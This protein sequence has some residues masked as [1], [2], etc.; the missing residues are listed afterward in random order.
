LY[1]S[2]FPTDPVVDARL[3]ETGIIGGD[4]TVRHMVTRVVESLADADQHFAGPTGSAAFAE[5]LG[6]Q[7]DAGRVV[8]SAPIMANAGRVTDRPLVTCAAPS[9]SLAGELVD[10][11]ASL[12]R[13]VRLGLGTGLRFDGVADPLALLHY[14]N[15]VAV[16]E[17][18]TGAAASAAGTLPV[19]H[20]ALL[21]LSHPRAEGFVSSMVG[22]GAA[23]ERWRFNV[24]LVVRDAEMR[25]A[26]A[27]DGRE[28]AVLLSTASAARAGADPGLLFVDRL[29][30][31]NPAPRSGAYVVTS[32]AG[33]VG[34]LAGETCTFGQVNV[35]KFFRP[36]PA[37]PVPIDFGAL[38]DTVY[39]LVR[40]LDDAVEAS[41]AHHPTALSA[42]VTGATR[43]I[44]V[45]VCGLADLLHAADVDYASREGR[46]LAQEVLA[47]L[48]YVAKLASIDLAVT[49]GAC[50]AVGSGRSRYASPN[51]LRRFADVD[52]RSVT[53]G[54]WGSLSERVAV[55]G[56]LRNAS[57]TAL[58]PT[59]DGAPVVG[60]SEGI[61]PLP[62]EPV[63][64][65]DQLTMA[66][67]A[68]ACV[69]EGV[70]TTLRLPAHATE[71]DV[72]DLFMAAWELGCT[73]IR[74]EIPPGSAS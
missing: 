55:S 8:F 18:A 23:G 41:A 40:A 67:A 36:R 59:R 50:A 20:A 72:Y 15:H 31:H 73:T 44:G 3:Q 9:V 12:E 4:E 54:D 38:A 2:T 74:S 34:L 39:T 63:D 25:A 64:P 46:H 13:H 52:V 1:R 70:A 10:L 71:A 47:Y 42:K 37:G 51:F 33:E 58:A 32:P 68:Q 57:I 60:A 62:K 61:E 5:R 56:M 26:V 7:I 22:A 29:E 19:E 35:G 45:G 65:M 24:S 28:R 27:Q 16:V 49:R 66:A 11:R 6:W 43:K 48:N 14:L 21:S 17:A 53:I 30:A 69:D